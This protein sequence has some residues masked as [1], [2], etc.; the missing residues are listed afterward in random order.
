MKQLGCSSEDADAVG[1]EHSNGMSGLLSHID[2]GRALLDT[3]RHDRTSIRSV[4]H[5]V[6]TN[7]VVQTQESVPSQQGYHLVLSCEVLRDDLCMPYPVLVHRP[8]ITL[9]ISFQVLKYAVHV[10]KGKV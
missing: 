4:S 9:C 7:I 3:Y 6:A 2:D 8:S 5:H 1:I 10:S